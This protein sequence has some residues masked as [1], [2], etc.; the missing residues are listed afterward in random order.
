MNINEKVEQLAKITAA[1][2][3]EVNELKGND[4]NSRLDE[5]EWE[6]EALKNDI[7]DLRYSLMQQNKKILSL[8]RAH[9]DKLLESIESD[10]LA[11]HIT[12][13]KKISE[14]V[15]RFPIK[16]IKELD[17]LEKY[18][19]RKNLNELV[20]VVQQLLTPQGIV[21]N[22]DA[23][24]STDCIVSCNVDGHHYKR[25][26][27]NYTKFMDLLFQAAYYDGYSQKVFLDDVRRG[28]KMAKNRH[29]KNVFRNRQLQRQ[30]QE[31]Q[32]EVDEAELIEVEP[33]YPLS[34]E[35]IKEEILCD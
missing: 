32:K 13:T 12:F 18:I 10:K 7:N 29:N 16:S 24:L 27:L 33:S 20:A 19:N 21:K 17:A 11:P 26:L 31:E 14:Q 5:L 23:V 3:N 2:T 15:K 4:V 22:I 9:N 28:L 8:I 25:R 35:L 1:L 34:E 30:E 6:K